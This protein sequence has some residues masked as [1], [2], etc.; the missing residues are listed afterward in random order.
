MCGSPKGG[1]RAS[2]APMLDPPMG[3]F[4]LAYHQYFL[5][6]MASLKVGSME[7]QESPPPPLNPPL[8]QVNKVRETWRRG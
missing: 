3:G 2:C 8:L 5:S 7:P 6:T 1:A 4:H